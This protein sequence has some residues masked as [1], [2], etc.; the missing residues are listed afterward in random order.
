MSVRVDLAA[1]HFLGAGDGDLRDLAA[2]LL[3]RAIDLDA[4]LGAPGLDL[5]FALSLAVGFAL[6]DDSG[7]AHVRLI[8]DASRLVASG[9]QD[10]VGLDLG[11]RERILAL[12]RRSEPI[13]DLGLPLLDRSHDERPDELHAEPDEY[14]HRDRLADQRQVY[15]HADSPR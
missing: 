4:D 2:Q 6:L 8:D 3:A 13:R 14:R 12:L 5:G 15:V 11:V 10:L 1:E 7:R 9:G